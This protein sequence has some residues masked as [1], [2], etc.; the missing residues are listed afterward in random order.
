MSNVVIM[1][2]MKNISAGFGDLL[3]GTIYLHQLSQKMKFNLIVDIQLHPVSQ[4]LISQ[5]HAHSDYVIQNQSNIIHAINVD[6][7]FIVKQ[8]QEH[9]Q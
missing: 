6:D 5:P 8:L 1:V 4:L 9:Q 7:Q 3:R 2:W